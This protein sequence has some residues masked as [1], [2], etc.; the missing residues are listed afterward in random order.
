MAFRPVANVRPAWSLVWIWLMPGNTYSTGSSTVVMFLPAEFTSSSD[1]YR[2][3]VLPA[4]VGPAQITM[5]NGAWIIF[6]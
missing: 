1:A 2:V 5:P 6:E 3:V 4:P